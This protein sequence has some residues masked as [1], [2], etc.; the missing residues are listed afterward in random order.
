MSRALRGQALIYLDTVRPAQ[1]ESL[2]EEALRLTDG[3]ADRE[4]RARLLELL[5]EN[6]L[7]MGQP[8]EAEA[9]ARRDPRPARGGT[10]RGYPERARQAAHRPA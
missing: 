9:P 5:A 1:A 4:A 2:L 8:A 10:G 7:N 6:K 3:A